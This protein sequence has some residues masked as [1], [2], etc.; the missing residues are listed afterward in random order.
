VD[1][2]ECLR[3]VSY[4][5][6]YAAMKGQQYKP[7]L[8][9]IFITRLPSQS[10]SAGLIPNVALIMGSNTDE[11]TA[12]FFG[13][14][15]K[16]NTTADVQKYVSSLG[17]G[18][19][20]ATTSRILDLYPDDP[21]LGCP[22]QTGGETFASQGLQYKRGAALTGDYAIHAGRRWI[23]NW[24]VNNSYFPLYT[25]RFD[26]S[27]WNGEEAD[28]TT[29]APVFVTHFTEVITSKPDML[30]VLYNINICADMLRV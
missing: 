4:P 6:L 7:I 24:H 23:A 13:P 19:D 18:L 17:N 10:F 15:G 27:P 26:Q 3:G 29:V 2:I 21:A 20:N 9:G 1:S 8:D 12:T 25:Y 28:V 22:F 14:R 5:E 16:L 30:T 11:G